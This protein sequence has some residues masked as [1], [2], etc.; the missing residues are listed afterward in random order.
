MIIEFLKSLVIYNKKLPKYCN[1]Y[2]QHWHSMCN[3]YLLLVARLIQYENGWPQLQVSRGQDT[4]CQRLSDTGCYQ[5]GIWQN[6]TVA[7]SWKG[8]IINKK[9]QGPLGPWFLAPVVSFTGPLINSNC[10]E[11]CLCCRHQHSWVQFQKL[12]MDK[13]IKGRTEL[14]FI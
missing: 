10:D 11:V 7:H 6:R 13:R 1:R 14:R 4:S 12:H 9:L 2:L 5:L 3:C 8:N